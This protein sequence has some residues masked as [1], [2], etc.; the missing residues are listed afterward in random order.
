[1]NLNTVLPIYI[2]EMTVFTSYSKKHKPTFVKGRDFCSLTYRHKGETSIKSGESAFVSTPDTIT[3]IPRGV[4][5]TT[6]IF[7]DVHI[8][9]IHF[10]YI[11]EDMPN[12]PC[13]ISAANQKIRSYF[14][15]LSKA[16]SDASSHL[17][18]MAILYE[19][20]DE[21]GKIGSDSTVKSIPEKIARS[22]EII[23]AS[24][25]DP[26]FCIESLA[27]KIGISSTYLRREFRRTYEV[28]PIAYLKGVRIESA[29]KLLLSQ[30]M[31]V[32][33]VG[34]ACGYSSTS[35]FIQYFHKKTGE[36]PN[37][38]RNRLRATP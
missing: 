30:N 17:R 15:L 23:D 21:L 22:R 4:S 10:N 24:Y 3:F 33:E 12:L 18:Q 28:S 14:L 20:L 36:S 29:V 19:L 1:M 2:T 16:V 7:E 11:G 31:T 37:Q 27:E 38:Y 35:Y 32:E 5:Y 8:T 13:M 25:S 26:F 9:A 34:A 6:E